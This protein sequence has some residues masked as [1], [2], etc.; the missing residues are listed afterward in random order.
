MPYV[1]LFYH[2]V[3]TTKGRL[4]LLRERTRTAIYGAMTT[5]ITDLGGIVYALDGMPDHVH[6]V[7]TIPPRHSLSTFIGQTKGSSSHIANY[8]A[9]GAVDLPFAWQSEYGVLSLSER[10][11]PLVVSY[12]QNQAEHHATHR[13]NATLENDGTTP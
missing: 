5:K 3:W 9:D 8:L 2:F 10:H 1:R 6:L 13:L 7:V 11:L 12:V 4:P